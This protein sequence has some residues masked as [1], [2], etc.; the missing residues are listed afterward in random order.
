M[1]VLAGC[2]TPPYR[3]P[4]VIAPVVVSQTTWREIDRDIVDASQAATEQAK[5]Y[6]RGSMEHWRTLV[7]ARTD[8]NFIPWFSNYWTQ[9]WMSMKVTWYMMSARDETE[10]S[11]KRLAVYLQEQYHDRVLAPVS[12]EIDPDAIMGQATEFYVQQMGQQRQVIAKRYGV[13]LAQ[14]D[15]RLNDIPAITLAPPATHNASLSQM[16][17]ANPLTSQ[18]AYAALINRIHN[19]GGGAGEGPS[20]AA[21]SSVAKQTS[22]KLEA[23]LASR[24]VASA[25][26]AA[27]GR[28]VGTVISMGA[29][30]I[31]AIAHESERPGIEAQVRKNLGTAFDS[32]WRNL[33]VNPNTGVMAGVLYL[34]AQIEG[35]LA[36]ILD[37][38]VKSE[39]VSR[40]I[41]LQG[42]PPPQEGNTDE[43]P[44]GDGE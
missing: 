37:S 20:Q 16:V 39:S 1:L 7:Y 21:I 32:A 12:V 34:S 8:E 28:V 14:L 24:G 11:E 36:K 15:Q 29:A 3:A 38:Q 17:H 41:L 19:A 6:A 22:D 43:Q 9:E 26:A 27:A 23:Q 33:L 25:V 31:R 5:I 40:V 13:P 42:E 30:G 18:P 35:N 4:E 10:L 2:V 44:I